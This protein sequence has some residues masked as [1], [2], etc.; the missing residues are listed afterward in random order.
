[1]LSKFSDG[2]NIL[3]SILSESGKWSKSMRW[4]NKT[5]CCSCGIS[6]YP[7]KAVPFLF[8]PFFNGLDSSWYAVDWGAV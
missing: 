6:F 4:H 3:I 5:G 2:V 8:C 1:M 7:L